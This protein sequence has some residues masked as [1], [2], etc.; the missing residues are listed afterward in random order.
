MFIL[1][2]SSSEGS[3]NFQKQLDFIA[4]V[5]ND[6]QIGV[7]NVQIGV[8]TF[9]DDVH[10]EFYLNTYNSKSAILSAIQ[11]IA[12]IQGKLGYTCG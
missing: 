2:A 8:L 11:R 10:K 5:V 12:Y 9:S 3:L 6:F 7:N 1:D 4:R